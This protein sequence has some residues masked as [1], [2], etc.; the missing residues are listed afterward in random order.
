MSDVMIER[1]DTELL[2]QV[3]A[4][5][6]REARMLDTDQHDAWLDL[7]TDDVQVLIPL[8]ANTSPAPHEIAMIK[9]DRFK[10]E[11][12]VWRARQT[13]TNHSQDPPSRVVR[14]VSNIEV[15]SS[16]RDDEVLVHF[17]TVLFDYRPGGQRAR[18]HFFTIPM[19]CEYRLRRTADGWRISWRQ[20]NLQL[21]DGTL[22]PMTFVL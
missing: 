19:R 3:S 6:L 13:G 15:E 12:R 2:S 22:P 5:I 20:L 10:T 4:I 9:E 11:A 17:V 7:L 8:G 18:N 16:D 1:T 21:R 14:A